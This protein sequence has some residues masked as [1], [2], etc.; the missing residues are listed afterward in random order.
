M[1]IIERRTRKYYFVEVPF[2][3]DL[4]NFGESFELKSYLKVNRN[5]LTR[6]LNK[7]VSEIQYLSV[8]RQIKLLFKQLTEIR[9][10]TEK[11]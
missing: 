4:V 9:Q 7:S 5:W 10:V 8:H 2:F 1:T 6:I 3:G 11:W